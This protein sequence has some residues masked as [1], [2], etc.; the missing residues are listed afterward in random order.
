MK[1]A[2]GKAVKSSTKKIKQTIKTFQEE[3]VD[4]MFSLRV[5][6]V[7][8]AYLEQF[9]DEWVQW[10]TENDDALK[11]TQFYNAKRI[12][13]STVDGWIKRCKKLEQAK[14]LVLQI[15]GARRECGAI[16]KKYD[17]AL[18]KYTMPMY[19][20]ECKDLE[21]W[22]AGLAAKINAAGGRPFEIIEVNAI[23][24][25]PEVPDVPKEKSS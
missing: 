7:D 21:E 5:R 10:A 19:D 17:P 25:C 22:R 14:E 23:D 4:G 20:K 2:T 16:N 24:S 1:K 3:F 8:I 6:P 18:I 12:H 9:A 11:I 13:N 15:I